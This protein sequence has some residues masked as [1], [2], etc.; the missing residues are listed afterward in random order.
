MGK[1]ITREKELLAIEL[2]SSGK[3]IAKVASM[4]R[5]DRYTV[6]GILERYS[7][8]LKSRTRAFKP[9][10]SQNGNAKL[11]ES[12]VLLIRQLNISGVARKELAK[13]FGISETS[14]NRIINNQTWKHVTLPHATDPGDA[15]I[16]S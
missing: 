15:V 13:Q 6:V 12:D 9:F 4:V 1:K 10:G 16:K 11:S 2:Y 3:T 5:I 8:P 14:I 7:I